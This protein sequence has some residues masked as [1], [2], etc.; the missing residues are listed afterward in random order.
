MPG[1][2]VLLIDLEN[3]FLGREK[4]FAAGSEPFSF[5]QEI[6]ELYRA[7]NRIAGDRRLVVQRAYA[8]YGA[9]RRL[10]GADLPDYFLRKTPELLMRLGIEPIQVYRYCRTRDRKLWAKNSADM[11]LAIDAVS[12][13]TSGTAFEQFII[14]TGDSDFIPLVVELR[15]QGAEVVVIGLRDSSNIYLQR[16][17]DRFE[18]FD[19]S[20]ASEEG[21]VTRGTDQ[22][23]I[24]QAA[25]SD[26]DLYRK[27][28]GEGKARLTIV[29]RSHW[30]AITER[31][32]E[33]FRGQEAAP[34]QEVCDKLT[35]SFEQDKSPIGHHDVQNVL[36]QIRQAKC[37]LYPGDALPTEAKVNW[38][39]RRVRL[40]PSICDL[41]SLRTRV[42]DYLRD[43]LN[44]RMESRRIGKRFDPQVWAQL[45]EEDSPV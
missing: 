13:M 37:F 6:A 45:L 34:Y 20:S 40:D 27:L 43:L 2:S 17:C 24:R 15:K 3:F 35:H 21:Q 25:S 23:A 14:V 16:F 10:E 12:L 9:S 44:Q 41:K 29:A 8:D 36:F 18:Y 32:F 1:N 4:N 26:I 33:M 5:E 7:A 38:R 30:D 42:R 22:T 28:L 39:D 31:F 19:G 11:R